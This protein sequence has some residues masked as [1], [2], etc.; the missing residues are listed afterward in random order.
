MEGIEVGGVSS[1][2]TKLWCREKV[3]DGV[4]RPFRDQYRER[5]RSVDVDAP[6]ELPTGAL[7]PGLMWSLSINVPI[8]S[9]VPLRFKLARCGGGSMVNGYAPW[10][11]GRAL[12][13]V[14]R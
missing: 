6:F 7:A 3:S 5:G 2:F 14:V 1:L 9:L 4:L 12:G 8:E 11:I 10:T 13:R